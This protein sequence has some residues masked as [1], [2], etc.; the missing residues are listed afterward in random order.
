MKKFK[1]GTPRTPNIMG[2]G[3][4]LPKLFIIHCSLFI[5]IGAAP[6]R[7]AAFIYLILISCPF[8]EES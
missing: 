3:G 6:R 4:A 2:E 5:K 7:S 8:S 1:A